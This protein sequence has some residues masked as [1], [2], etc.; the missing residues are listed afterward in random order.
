MK[1]NEI[2]KDFK[3]D[4]ENVIFT[5]NQYKTLLKWYLTE[6][7]EAKDDVLRFLKENL[8]KTMTLYK[9]TKNKNDFKDIEYD[10]YKKAK[11]IVKDKWDELCKEQVSEFF[12]E[13]KEKFEK[14]Q[15]INKHGQWLGCELDENR[16]NYDW[17]DFYPEIYKSEDDVRPSIGVYFGKSKYNHFGLTFKI[18]YLEGDEKYKQCINCFQELTGKNTDN[19]R[20]YNE[21]YYCDKFE[22]FSNSKEEYAFIY[23][24]INNHGDW[25]AEFSKILE[26]FLNKETI[27][28]TLEKINEILKPSK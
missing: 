23:W 10:K 4:M 14:A 3:E 16:F 8:E 21:H 27:K 11:D 2:E 22:N 9:Y 19:V 5:L 13:L 12:H 20:R 17:F 15:S 25:T 28:S 6:E 7:F 26:E 24:L 1:K 18:N